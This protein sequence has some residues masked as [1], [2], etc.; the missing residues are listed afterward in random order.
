MV[1]DQVKRARLARGLTQEA[2]A[3]LAG[4]PRKQLW[5]LE[6]D[7]LVTIET[8]RRVVTALEMPVVA[9][10]AVDVL[11]GGI[12]T[13]RVL[14]TAEKAL[15]AVR[16]LVAVL[17]AARPRQADRSPDEALAAAAVDRPPLTPDHPTV[18]MLHELVDQLAAGKSRVRP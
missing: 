14:E 4:V 16:A 8:F 13:A 10:G 1:G 12:D 18:K 6:N 7:K 15:E 3:K 11:P 17:H 2:A 5:K 9:F